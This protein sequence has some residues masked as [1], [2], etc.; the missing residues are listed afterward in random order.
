MKKNILIIEDD[1][2]TIDFYKYLFVK[3]GFNPIFIENGDLLIDTI[4]QE[5]ISLI[6][7]DINLKNSYFKG[8]KTDGIQLSRFL[9][10]K[11]EYS[12]IPII[13]VTAYSISLKGEKFFEES[14]ANDMMTKPITDFNLM[15]NKVNELILN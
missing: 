2:F 1:I 13:L 7:M 14:L 11:S 8:E 6:I 15:I 12:H 5:K 4:D 9:K 10:T 3:A